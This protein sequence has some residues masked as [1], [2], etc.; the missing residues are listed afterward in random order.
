[1]STGKSIKPMCCSITTDATIG[2][3]YVKA[4]FLFSVEMRANQ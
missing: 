1:M 2:M 4:M 3:D